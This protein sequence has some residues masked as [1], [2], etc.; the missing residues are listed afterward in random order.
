MCGG[1]TAAFV[2][3]YLGESLTALED[4]RC[5]D[6]PAMSALKGVDLVTEGLLTIRRLNIYA[7][8]TR[9]FT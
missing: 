7:R 5:D 4:T 9:N 6:I 8:Q 1:T 2:A 3:D